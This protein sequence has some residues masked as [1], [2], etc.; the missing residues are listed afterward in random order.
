MTEGQLE[1]IWIKRAHKG[2]MDPVP[3]AD[4]VAGKGLQGNANVGGKR[5]VTLIERE[6]WHDAQ[7]VLDTDLDPSA[8]RANL[9]VS[10]VALERGRGRVL[11][12]G[13]C[14]LQ[15]HGETRPCRQMEETLTGLQAYLGE[16]W[17]G[18]VFAE[19]LDSGQIR[20]GDPVR[21]EDEPGAG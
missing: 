1:A 11:R 15:V 5:Q 14:R 8:R 7:A 19:A 18:G 12:I 13:A 9:M 10:G 6:V 16:H 17:R 3:E 4:L 20:V 2:P 21:W